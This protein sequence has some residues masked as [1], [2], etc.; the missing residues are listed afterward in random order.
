MVPLATAVVSLSTKALCVTNAGDSRGV[1][2][3]AG[4]LSCSASS[5]APAQTHCVCAHPTHLST[6]RVQ[7]SEGHWLSIH[8]LLAGAQFGCVV[9]PPANLQ[10][11]PFTW[12]QVRRLLLLGIPKSQNTLQTLLRPGGLQGAMR[13]GPWCAVRRLG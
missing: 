10:Q 1:L 7:P 6:A 8:T 12:L 5:A 13:A 9:K 11:T 4:L 3:Q 2:C